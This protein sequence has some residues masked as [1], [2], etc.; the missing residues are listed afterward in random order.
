MTMPTSSNPFIKSRKH[1]RTLQAPALAMLAGLGLPLAAH[2][3]GPDPQL[4]VVQVTAP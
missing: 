2:A 1:A 4:P 3:E